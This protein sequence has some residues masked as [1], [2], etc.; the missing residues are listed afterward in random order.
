[1]RLVPAGAALA[2]VLGLLTAGPAAAVYEDPTITFPDGTS[3]FYSPFSGPATVTFTFDADSS[4]ATFEL[5]IRPL[6][7]GAIHTKQVFIDPDTQSSP[8]DVSFSWPAL[9][10]TSS[11]T[12]QVAVYRGGNLQGSPESF[13]LRPALVSI[14]GSRRTRS[15]L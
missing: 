8:R 11:R 4:D 1:M 6:G 12:Y 2:L 15:S 7:G 13:L 9:S 14:T 5:R 10:V 3:E